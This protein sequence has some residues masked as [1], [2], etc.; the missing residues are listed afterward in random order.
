[1]TGAAQQKVYKTGLA[2]AILSYSS[3]GVFPL[4]WKMLS[5]VPA[6]QILAHRV[7]WSVLFLFIILIW[8]RD[9]LFLEYLTT[10]KTLFILIITGLLIGSNWFIY[11]YAV[12]SNHI[13]DASLGYYI[14]PIVNVLLGTIFLK[15]RLNRIQF[16]AIAL[17]FSGVTYLTYSLGRLPVISVFL[18]VSFALYGLMRKKA[19]LQSMPG[20]MVE[21]LLLSP[22]ALWYLWHVE[23]SGNGLS[24][25]STTL[26]DVLLILGGPVT[27]LPL[28]W[29][30]NAAT[31]VPLSTLGFIQ[32][33]SPTLQL[34]VGIVVFH[35]KFDSAYMVAFGLVWTG[36]LLFTY[37][38]FKS[39]NRKV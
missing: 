27:A 5:N 17:A 38:I 6:D 1:M 16:I 25:H 18:A 15:E 35:E 4:Y 39:S 26:T 8:R 21:T 14:N 7:V 32:Y 13:V 36:L 2:Y 10:R 37:S 22:V 24:L 33:L 3:W 19:G 12:N 23:T 9:K 20:L 31:R 28:F 34:L 11:I 29:F 30:G